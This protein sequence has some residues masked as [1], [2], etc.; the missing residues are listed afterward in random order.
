MPFAGCGFKW[1]VHSSVEET[2]LS[3]WYGTLQLIT[4]HLPG[5]DKKIG[6]NTGADHVACG[7]VGEHKFIAARPLRMPEL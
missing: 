4:S 5:G 1:L 2:S 7:A 3:I 6:V